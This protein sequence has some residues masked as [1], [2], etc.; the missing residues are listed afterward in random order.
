MPSYAPDE[1]IETLWP[2][3]GGLRFTPGYY[4]S[5]SWDGDAKAA[6]AGIDLSAAFGLPAGIKA[7]ACRMRVKDETAAVAAALS[8][9]VGTPRNGVGVYTQIANVE[10]VGGGI[11]PCDA[12]GDVYFSLS[13]ELDAVHIDIVGYWS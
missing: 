1:L 4:T 7:I 10:N 12:S 8:D 2:Q 9:V 3:L 5:T 6:S 11:V 13:G